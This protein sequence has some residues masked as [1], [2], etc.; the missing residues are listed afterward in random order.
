[1]SESEKVSALISS[2]YNI[3]GIHARIYDDTDDTAQKS[4]LSFFIM[5][6]NEI[7]VSGEYS[8]TRLVPLPA[9]EW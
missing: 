6:N 7:P 2:H 4:F 9:D 5:T 3:C 8:S 1:M